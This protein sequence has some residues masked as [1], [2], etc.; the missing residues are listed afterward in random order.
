MQL[1][2]LTV[3]DFSTYLSEKYHQ[4]FEFSAHG[5]DVWSSRYDTAIFKDSSGSKFQVRHA[6]DGY[7]DNYTTVLYD[8]EIESRFCSAI[9]YECKVYANTRTYFSGA[10]EIIDS[11]EKYLD[12]MPAMSMRVYV[13]EKDINNEIANQLVNTFPDSLV[14]C[15]VTVVGEDLYNDID[16]NSETPKAKDILD[17]YTFSMKNG[18]IVRKS[19]EG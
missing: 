6:D 4:N 17:M 13:K 7:T 9:Q 5:I 19:W 2:K 15:V 3:E 14:T 10:N 12:C 8:N 1:I 16:R 11:F 18:Q